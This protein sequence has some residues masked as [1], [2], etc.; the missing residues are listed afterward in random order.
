[1]L[2]DICKKNEATIHIKEMHHGKWTSLNLCAECAK[3]NNLD[4]PPGDAPQLDIARLDL[5]K[6]ASNIPLVLHGGSGTPADQLAAAIAHGICKVNIYSELL[7]AWNSEMLAQ[8]QEL[9]HMA[10]WPAVLRK[11]PDAAMRE[12]IRQ[13]I[14]FFGSDNKC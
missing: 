4:T 7:T 3:N 5:I 2:C 13:K 10:A 11:K 6:A 1:M 8:L 9:P 12:V 14:R